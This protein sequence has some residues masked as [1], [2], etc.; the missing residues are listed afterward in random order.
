[1]LNRLTICYITENIDASAIVLRIYDVKP[2]FQA[3]YDREREIQCVKLS[4]ELGL[5]PKC[6]CTFKNGYGT[7]FMPGT[8]YG[9]DN[10]SLDEFHDIKMGR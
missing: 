10:D 2:R 1:M 3:L 6:C 7:E 4:G 9:W 8:T 5:G